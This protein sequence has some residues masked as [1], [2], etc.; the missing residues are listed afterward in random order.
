[1]AVIHT[2]RTKLILVGHREEPVK[3]LDRETHCVGLGLIN[4]S[5]S[6]PP[7]CHA[8]SPSSLPGTHNLQAKNFLVDTNKETLF[9]LVMHTVIQEHQTVLECSTTLI[10]VE[11]T[12]FYLNEKCN[13][14]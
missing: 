7:P 5:S 10:N 13:F 2:V 3:D 12:I 6:S 1:M 14:V 8:L 4:A 9:I 11:A